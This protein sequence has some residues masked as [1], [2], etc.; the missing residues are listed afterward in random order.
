MQL[1]PHRLTSRDA[2]LTIEFCREKYSTDG[3]ALAKDINVRRLILHHLISED[4]DPYSF[5]S[6]WTFLEA[7]RVLD[8]DKR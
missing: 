6:E 3:L 1:P 5:L 8:F 2:G 7:L 4:Q